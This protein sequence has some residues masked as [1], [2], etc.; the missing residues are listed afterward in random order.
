MDRASGHFNILTQNLFHAVIIKQAVKIHSKFANDHPSKYHNQCTGRKLNKKSTYSPSAALHSDRY[1][2]WPPR[3][4]AATYE[5]SLQGTIECLIKG[6]NIHNH[7]LC[8]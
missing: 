2:P 3:V 6:C 4:S 1:G 7:F 5:P 8:T